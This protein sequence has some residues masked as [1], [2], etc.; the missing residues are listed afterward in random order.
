M[1]NEKPILEGYWS[2][3]II[4]NRFIIIY[5]SFVKSYGNLGNK[6]GHVDVVTV[7]VTTKGVKC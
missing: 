7:Q 5:K 4:F 6:F 2:I 3:F 1:E